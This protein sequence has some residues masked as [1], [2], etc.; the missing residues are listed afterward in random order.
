MA[1]INAKDLI[2]L[3]KKGLTI[4]LQQKLMELQERELALREENLSLKDQLK[5]LQDSIKLK[6][7]ITYDGAM[8]WRIHDD[9]KE[10]PFCQLCYDDGGKLIRLQEGQGTTY[11]SESGNISRRFTYHRCYKC[12]RTFGA[13]K[14]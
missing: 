4:E 13:D 10:G 1:I 7:T 12:D 9:I 8:Y 6:A 2:E 5:V 3:A 14:D 11:D